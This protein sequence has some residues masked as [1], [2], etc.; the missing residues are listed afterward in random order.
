MVHLS[1]NQKLVM[2]LNQFVRTAG[3]DYRR[4]PSRYLVNKFV[5][6]R[7]KT[8]VQQDYLWFGQLAYRL[9]SL[10][11]HAA[12]SEN[13]TSA[14]EPHHREAKIVGACCLR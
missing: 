14:N 13:S 5:V 11:V 1:Q 8:V 7:V 2:H 9:D 10:K 6:R 4:S 3:K 12:R